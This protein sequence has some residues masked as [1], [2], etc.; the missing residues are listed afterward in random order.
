MQRGCEYRG[1]V[2]TERVRYTSS[3]SGAKTDPVPSCKQLTS[4]QQDQGV[5]FRSRDSSGSEPGSG[6]QQGRGELWLLVAPPAAAPQDSTQG[7]HLLTLDPPPGPSKARLSPRAFRQGMALRTPC[8]HT[9]SSH[10]V[11]QHIAIFL[12]LPVCGS[13]LQQPQEPN[14]LGL[15]LFRATPLP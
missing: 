3:L 8:F 14:V 13:S 5:K 9:G 12:S 15:T 10:T 7:A 1:E 2:S 11:R 4:D 6:A